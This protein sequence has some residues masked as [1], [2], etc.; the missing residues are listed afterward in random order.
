MK[1]NYKYLLIF[2]IVF[3]SSCS[4][5]SNNDLVNIA[6]KHVVFVNLIDLEENTTSAEEGIDEVVSDFNYYY[7]VIKSEYAKKK[8]IISKHSDI[9]YVIIYENGNCE[10]ITFDSKESEV[11]IIFS[12]GIK[13][14]LIEY[15]VM[16]DI[17]IT[18][19]ITEY[20]E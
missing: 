2:L 9:S 16:T 8:I 6:G 5:C 18:A 17:D 12:D 15:G 19:V 11:G 3:E 20:F 10:N 1:S 13:D 4:D 7:E 14:P